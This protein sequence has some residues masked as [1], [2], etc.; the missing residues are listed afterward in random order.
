LYAIKIVEKLRANGKAV[1]L[2]L[3]GEGIE[4][5]NLRKLY[6]KASTT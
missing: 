4:R 2:K 1:S 6:Y 5:A 3:Y